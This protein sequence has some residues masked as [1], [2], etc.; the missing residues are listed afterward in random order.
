M[1]SI[2]S[3][4]RVSFQISLVCLL[5]PVSLKACQSWST[6]YVQMTPP[7]SSKP[8]SNS[9]NFFQMVLDM[10]NARCS[11]FYIVL[12]IF[13][14]LALSIEK[15]STVIKIIRADVLPRFAEFL[16][17]HGLPQLQVCSLLPPPSFPLFFYFL[18]YLT[19]C[20]FY[21]WRLPGFLPT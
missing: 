6:N 19:S 20:T 12:Y 4:T 15:N 16:S 10:F 1:H 3:C 11:S 18:V 5:Y 17:R 2:V 21:R 14:T 13:L 9:G 7:V 8:Q